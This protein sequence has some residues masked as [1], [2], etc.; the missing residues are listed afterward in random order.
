M[1]NP[2]A[3]E[4][5][6]AL[7]ATAAG[8]IVAGSFPVQG[9][10]TWLAVVDSIKPAG[11]PTWEQGRNDA[12]AEYRREAGTRALEAKRA[13]LDSMLAGGMT[14][15]S[16]AAYWGGMQR[17]SD[18]SAGRSLPFTGTS[19]EV[20]SLL[21]GGRKSEPGLAAGKDS[22]WIRSPGGLTRLRIVSRTVP[23]P[24]QVAERAEQIRKATVE[25]KLVAYFEELKAR[26]P[27]VILDRRLRDLSLFANPQGAQAH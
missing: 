5:F 10:G 26:Y 11:T 18:L 20:D 17:V 12:I 2:Q 24:E 21:F 8:H 14:L 22:G 19:E 25:Q 15:D 6:A 4:F 3:Q 7:R 1:P 9:Q 27:V 23:T 16:L 13:E